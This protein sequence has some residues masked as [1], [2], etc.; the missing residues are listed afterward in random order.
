MTESE[1]EG[2]VYLNPQL[3][4]VTENTKRKQNMGDITS[5]EVFERILGEELSKKTGVTIYV[6]MDIARAIQEKA[7]S[8]GEE[9]EVTIRHQDQS[10]K[11]TCNTRAEGSNYSFNC[12]FKSDTHR[13]KVQKRKPVPA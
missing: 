3:K 6:P 10:K 13:V 4:L 7:N 11:V 9:I 1:Q 2:N 5:V 12:R 8:H